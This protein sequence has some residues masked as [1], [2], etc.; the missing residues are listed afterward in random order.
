MTWIYVM[1]ETALP[2]GA[3]APVYPLGVNVVIARIGGTIHAVSGKCAHMGCP[4]F[5][6]TL[7][8]HTLTCPCHD[9]R[10]D[11]RTGRFLEASELG[12]TVYPI[13]AE[14]GKLFVSVG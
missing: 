9:W 10:F 12:L 2:E 11:V 5:T 3:M 4:L 7:D 14:S 1:D 8:G 13:K 6:G